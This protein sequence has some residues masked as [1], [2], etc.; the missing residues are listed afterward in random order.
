MSTDVADG[1][2][3]GSAWDGLVDDDDG[4]AVG[5][6]SVGVEA[7]GA[8][9]VDVFVAPVLPADNCPLRTALCIYQV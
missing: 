1:R 5:W 9:V 3:V 4:E 2:L 8:T 6:A 7:K